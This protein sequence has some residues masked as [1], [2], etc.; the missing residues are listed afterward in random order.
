MSIPATSTLWIAR[1]GETE[2]TLSGRHTGVTDLPLSLAGEEQ[3]RRLGLRLKSV[4][5]TKVF[6]SPLQRAVRTCEL[7]GCARDVEIDRDLVEWNYGEYEG[8]KRAEIL[9]TRP[10]WIVF[11]DGCPGGES[12]IDVARRADRFISRVR[13]LNGDVAAFSSGHFS[14]VLMARWLGLDSSA[15]RYFKFGTAA[16]AVLGYDHQSPEEPVIQLLNERPT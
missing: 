14:R 1:H 15:G 13:L 16:L 9:S 7:A 11:R 12:P 2:W 4:N 6:C 3:A 5:F 8:K 10:G